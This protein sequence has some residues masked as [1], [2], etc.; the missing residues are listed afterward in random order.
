MANG[1]SKTKAEFMAN[2]RSCFPELS[3]VHVSDIA[4]WVGYRSAL[5]AKKFA[6]AEGFVEL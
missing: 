3:K 6:D 4:A 1:V 5:Q 2:L